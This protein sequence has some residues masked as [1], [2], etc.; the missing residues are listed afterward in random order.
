MGRSKILGVGMGKGAR[1]KRRLF[2]GYVALVRLV[3]SWS[4]TPGRTVY[5]L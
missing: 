1:G 5:R 2:W 4:K 3:V